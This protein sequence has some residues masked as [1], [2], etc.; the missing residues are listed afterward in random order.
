MEH[1][2]GK[3]Y[4]AWKNYYFLLQ[5]AHLLN[6]LMVKTDLFGKLQVKLLLK[7]TTKA[8]GA[9]LK[10]VGATAVAFYG[11]VKNFIKHLG[12][13]FRYKPF[14]EFGRSM[15]YPRSIQIRFAPFDSS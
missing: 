2:Y 8:T 12:E 1:G 10:F 15:E 3:K 11:S 14:T 5:L 13:S 9:L 6:Q 7:N 4:H